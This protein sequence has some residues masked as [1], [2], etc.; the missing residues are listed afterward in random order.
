MIKPEKYVEFDDRTEFLS[1][2]PKNSICAELGVLRAGFSYYILKDTSPKKLYLVD[3]YWKSY[4]ENFYWNKK[5]TWESFGYAVETIKKYD[6]NKCSTFV[7]DTDINFLE[8]LSDNVFDWIYLDS[9]HTYEDTLKEL[10]VIK[11]K[12]K[13]EGLICGHDYTDNPKNR[14]AGVT[15][16]II[17]WLLK[18]KEYKLY[19]RDNYT[20]W[21]IK[22]R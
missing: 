15:K 21:I 20:Q 11:L 12:V 10:E 13:E 19:L 7:I 22:K 4:G 6:I 5:S 9:T 3:P 16:A 17:E 1:L 18:N 2:L 8:D 14:H